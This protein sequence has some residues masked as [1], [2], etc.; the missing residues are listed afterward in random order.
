MDR[1]LNLVTN[2]QPS[3]KKAS[4]MT[5]INSLKTTAKPVNLLKAG[6]LGLVAGAGF[7]FIAIPAK[8]DEEYGRIAQ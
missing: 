4:T 2:Q 6:L 8:A 7:G 3:V 5:T 1:A